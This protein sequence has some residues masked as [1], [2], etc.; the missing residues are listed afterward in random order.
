MDRRLELVLTRLSEA[1]RL[2]DWDVSFWRWQR[3]LSRWLAMKV[4]PPA[5]C[6]AAQLFQLAE[7]A[8]D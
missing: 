8:L 2:K 7:R 4:R 5:S 3:E 1:V 6:A